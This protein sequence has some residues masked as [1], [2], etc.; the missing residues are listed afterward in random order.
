MTE[1]SCGVTRVLL[2]NQTKDAVKVVKR[3]GIAED[4][5]MARNAAG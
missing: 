4:K 3:M 5:M 2:S 1:A